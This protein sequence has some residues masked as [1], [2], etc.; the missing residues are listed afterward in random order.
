[1]TGNTKFYLLCVGAF[2]LA[3]AVMLPKVQRRSAAPSVALATSQIPGWLPYEDNS[4]L[5]YGAPSQADPIYHG[6]IFEFQPVT[7]DQR[8]A[9]EIRTH[10]DTERERYTGRMIGRRIDQNLGEQQRLIDNI[11]RSR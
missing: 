7:T 3:F 8:S 2:I 5:N 11:G 10:G 9:D 6:R 1:M 4:K